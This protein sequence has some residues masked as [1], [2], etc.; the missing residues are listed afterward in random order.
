[1]T[2]RNHWSYYLA[3][4]M[5]EFVQNRPTRNG[6]PFRN[7]EQPATDRQFATAVQLARMQLWQ[8]KQRQQCHK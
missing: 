1:M 4:G 3:R 8:E 5:V 7:V 2:T 6:N